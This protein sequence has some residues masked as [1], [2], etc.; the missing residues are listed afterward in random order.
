MNRVIKITV[1]TLF[2]VAFVSCKH[3]NKIDVRM[4]DCEIKIT[5][6]FNIDSIIVKQKQEL[7]DE[8]INEYWGEFVQEKI[9]LLAKTKQNRNLLF[10]FSDVDSAVF[11]DYENHFPNQRLEMKKPKYAVILCKEKIEAMIDLVNDPN[12]FTYGDLGTQYYD[13]EIIFYK[14]GKKK[15]TITF[16]KH[17]E[18]MKFKPY[19]SLA[20]S[21]LLKSEYST[22][23]F[24]IAP[25]K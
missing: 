17:P 24:D 10:P 15:A 18:Q 7:A 21:G 1:L 4:S 3:K 20:N 19:N 23:L 25:W 2:A 9:E 13:A 16:D 22:K 6:K 14:S 11:I 8:N 5:D 12:N